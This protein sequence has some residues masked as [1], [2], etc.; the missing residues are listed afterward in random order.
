MP[1]TVNMP[2]EVV[3]ETMIYMMLG[4]WNDGFR[5]IIIVNNHGQLWMLE[6]AIQE[7][8]KRFQLPE[9]SGF[10]TGTVP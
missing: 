8:C 2:Q 9:Y 7:F 6:T 3:V 5:K 1:G 10:W 4:L